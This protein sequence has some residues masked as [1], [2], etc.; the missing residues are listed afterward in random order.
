MAAVEPATEG[1]PAL[2]QALSVALG[3]QARLGAAAQRVLAAAAL[4]AARRGMDT[5]PRATPAVLAF[6]SQL[7]LVRAPPRCSRSRSC[8]CCYARCLSAQ[9]D[10]R[11]SAAGTDTFASLAR[12]LPGARLACAGCQ[13]RSA[14][15]DRVLRGRHQRRCT[16]S[17]AAPLQ[18]HS[19]HSAPMRQAVLP[20]FCRRSDDV[21][22]LPVPR[23]VS[24]LHGRNCQPN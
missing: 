3:A 13:L 8:C 9:G 12:L 15:Q 16:T 2:R 19:M 4:P 18:I 14:P 10:V 7:L 24:S 20:A 17:R 5:K 11:V 6:V 21:I 23:I 22:I 1:H